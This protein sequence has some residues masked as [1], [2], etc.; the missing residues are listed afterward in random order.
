MNRSIFALDGITG[1]LIATVLLL[2]IL[3]GL[4]VWGLGVQQANSETYYTI[5]NAK[6]IK[7]ISTEN[8]NH[9]KVVK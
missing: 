8:V 6:D 5:E 2:S 3:A 4:T 1:M 7:M 9:Y